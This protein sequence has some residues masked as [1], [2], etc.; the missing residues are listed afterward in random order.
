MRQAWAR[1][2]SILTI[3]LLLGGCSEES[4]S[5]AE[6]EKAADLQAAV[7]PVGINISTRVAAAMYGTDGGAV[8]DDVDTAG[9]VTNEAAAVVGHRFALR[10]TEADIDD[11]DYLRAVV[12][13]YCP[14]ELPAF[15]DRVDSLAVG[16]QDD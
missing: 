14:D 7:A 16:K 15:E 4:I 5:D 9:A 12:R 13:T 11:V 2:G 3:V 10:K 8:C 1:A 6:A